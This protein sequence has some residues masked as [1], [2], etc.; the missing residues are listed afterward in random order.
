M[1]EQT[2]APAMRPTGRT[3][4]LATLQR[5]RGDIIGGVLK[6]D[7]R[8][9]FERLR[10]RYGVS[11]GTLREAL[12]Q[13]TAE[14][15]IK[16]EGQRGFRVSPIS[17]EDLRDVVRMRLML[18]PP[19]LRD[20][21]ERGDQPW[22][23][24][25]RAAQSTARQATTR[26]S[27]AQRDASRFEA[28]AAEPLFNALMSA[29]NSPWQTYFCGL[30]FRHTSRYW[31]LTDPFRQEPGLLLADLVEL[32]DAALARD[33]ERAC[34]IHTASLDSLETRIFP[35]LERIQ[36]APDMRRFA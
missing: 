32:A 14:G 23:D 34:A 4:A 26:R 18:D 9:R 31:W 27:P 19:T 13:L 25:I 24:R 30:L 21:I 15:L 22:T 11:V 2:S 8:L 7:E 36:R 10:W 5:L 35:H 33:A 20:A 1:N 6:P 17:I 3:L 28:A 12:V 16:M 29:C